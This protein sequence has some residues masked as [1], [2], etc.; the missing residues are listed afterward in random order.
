MIFL[1]V[2][3]SISI[4]PVVWINYVFKKN[5]EILPNMPFNGIE[6]GNQLI[7]ELELKDVC[8]EKTLIGDHYD[9][10]QKKVKVGEDRL[11]KKSL[12]SISIICHEI[13]HAIQHAENYTPLITRTKLVKNTLWINK[14]AFA[15][16]YIGLPIIFATGYLPLIK[17]CILLIL[18]SLFIGVI[19]HLVTLEVELDASFNKAMPIIKKKIPEVYHDSCR[20]ILR[21]AAFTYVVGVFKNLISLRMIWTVLS[22]IR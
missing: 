2:L 14:I 22:R 11:R 7:K 13:G 15:V 10:D 18:L 6:F 19:I 8:L 9:L 4:L 16:I 17:V 20:S 1:I 12:T 3:F 21:A 5:D